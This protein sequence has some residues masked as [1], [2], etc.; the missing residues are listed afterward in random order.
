MSFSARMK[1]M[2]TFL[3][4]SD[5]PS[6]TRQ[7]FLIGFQQWHSNNKV[8]FYFIYLYQTSIT[9]QQ[10]CSVV[11]EQNRY[12]RRAVCLTPTLSKQCLQPVTEP[13]VHRPV[14]SAAR[15]YRTLKCRRRCCEKSGEEDEMH[16]VRQ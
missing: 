3:P 5:V 16:L 11:A 6:Q 2:Q 13:S 7:A 1:Q 9:V 15:L 12:S 14:A 10:V 8:L 4:D